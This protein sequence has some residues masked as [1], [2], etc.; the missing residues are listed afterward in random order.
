MRQESPGR[1][2]IVFTT[3]GKPVSFLV[4]FSALFPAYNKALLEG[5]QC[6]EIR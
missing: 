3:Q 4:D 2:R 6:K 1:F 5:F